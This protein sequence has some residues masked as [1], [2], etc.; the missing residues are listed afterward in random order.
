V[1]GLLVAALA[2]CS[3]A[4]A[5]ES[6]PEAAPALGVTRQAAIAI[7][8]DSDFFPYLCQGAQAGDVM[9]DPVTGNRER[10]MVGDAIFPAFYRAATP[11]HV[12]FRMRIDANPL[13][14]NGVDMQPSSWDVLVNTDANLNTYEFMHTVDGNMAGT[15]VRWVRNSIQEPGNPRDPANDQA[16]DLLADFTPSTDYYAVKVAPDGSAFSGDPDYFVTL[17]IPKATLAAAGL[18]LSQSFVVW[19]G[20]NAQNYSLNADFGCYVGIPPVLGDADMDPGPLDPAGTP[21]AIGDTVTLAENT[22]VTTAV[23]ANDTGL[24]DTPLTVTITVPP[25]N[26]TAVVK[27]GNTVTY[28]PAANYDGPDSYT[29]QVQDVDGQSDVA[30]V[31]VTVTPVNAPLRQGARHRRRW[32][33]RPRHQCGGVRRYRSP[34]GVVPRHPPREATTG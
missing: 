14:N 30:T 12:F 13:R 8:S 7:P 23:L 15:K 29:Y 17:V 22:S 4:P 27:T 2:A 31:S 25:A 19:G 21:D 33:E 1:V 18:N 16:G 34:P 3:E 5:V 32:P 20:T 10:D 9:G 11:T 6:S 26:G 28:T 24:R